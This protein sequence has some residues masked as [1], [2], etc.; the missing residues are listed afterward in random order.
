MAEEA[1]AANLPVLSGTARQ[2]D[3]AN[4]IRQHIYNMLSRTDRYRH[5]AACCQH[6]TQ[7]SWWIDN[8]NA[9][10]TTIVTHLTDS[11]RRAA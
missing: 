3:W 10:T 7:A 8:R 5:A 11:G 9:P 4:A 1:K 2:V 6:E